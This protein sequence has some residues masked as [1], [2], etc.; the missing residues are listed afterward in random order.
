[1]NLRFKQRQWLS[2]A[3]VSLVYPLAD[4][5]NCRS[6]SRRLG[7]YRRREGLS[8]EANRALQWRALS[9][10][11]Q[12]AYDTS[13]FYR[14]RFDVAGERPAQITSP[15]DLKRIPPL[16]RDDIRKHL[17]QLRSSKY[18]P[19]ELT[20][21]ATGGTTDTPVRLLRDRESIRDKKAV[22]WRFNTWAGF[23][24]GDKVFYLWGARRDYVENPSWRWRLYDQHLMRRVWAPASL[25][26]EAVL[27][28][29]RETMNRFRPRVIYAYPTPLGLF[30]EFLRSGGRPYHRPLSAICTAEPLLDGQRRTIEEVFGCRVFDRYATRDFGTIAAECEHHQGLHLN[31]AAA[32]VEYLPLEGTGVEGL[33]EILVTDLL[34]YGMP[35]IRYRIND[36]IL[37][38]PGQCACGRGYPLIS[39]ITG[40][41][42]EV[43][44]LPNGD[45]VP[46]ISLHRVLTEDCPGVKKIQII[47]DSLE[48]FR[49]RFVTSETFAQ[50]D[51][52]TMRRRLDERF[53]KSVY[54]TFERVDEIERERSG[55][56]RFCISH[57]TKPAAERSQTAGALA[58]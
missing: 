33:H 52:Q 36:C 13:P 57:V 46:G 30:C 47:Q 39:G 26:N 42:T 20:H 56:T 5:Q 3:Y 28:S 15:S 55:K 14:R 49:L 7:H 44:R 17:S 12:H 9:Q 1:M 25:F 43:F 40:R 6:L 34:N 32:Y 51:L 24:P 4:P 41:T 50:S 8:V 11:L 16:T 48:E 35:L 53:G 38:A 19:E 54:W 58:P 2:R 23:L 45:A 18:R 27:E 22:E 37:T 31:T 29:Y 21:A 10:L